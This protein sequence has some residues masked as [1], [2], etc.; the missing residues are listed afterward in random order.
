M[1]HKTPSYGTNMLL[2]LV[3]DKTTFVKFENSNNF[4]QNFDEKIKDNQKSI[5]KSIPARGF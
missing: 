3:F 4:K 1:P 2:K 5:G